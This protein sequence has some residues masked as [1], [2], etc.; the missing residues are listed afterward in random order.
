[1]SRSRATLSRRSEKF[2]GTQVS[3]QYISRYSSAK[4]SPRFEKIADV[5]CQMPDKKCIVPGCRDTLIIRYPESGIR[6]P[7]LT[8]RDFCSHVIDWQR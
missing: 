7:F 1:M 2:D 8:S 3:M 6:D 4:I 5:G